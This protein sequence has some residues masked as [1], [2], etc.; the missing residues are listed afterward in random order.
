MQ[1]NRARDPLLEAYVRIVAH[2]LP[3]GLQTR[4]QRRT[5]PD[6]DTAGVWKRS[7]RRGNWNVERFVEAHQCGLIGSDWYDRQD[8]LDYLQMIGG[9]LRDR[10]D[11][12][13]QITRRR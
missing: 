13:G 2:P 9:V 4:D 7:P 5:Q 3:H 8:A 6:D 10:I 1:R 11:V 12:V